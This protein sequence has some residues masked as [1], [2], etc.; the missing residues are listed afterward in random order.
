MTGLVSA[1]EFWYWSCPADCPPG[2]QPQPE[3]ALHDYATLHVP[4]RRSPRH[5]FCCW[6][7]QWNRPYSLCPLS[8]SHSALSSF[9]FGAS[10]RTIISALSWH[11]TLSRLCDERWALTSCATSVSIAAEATDVPAAMRSRHLDWDW[12]CASSHIGILC[13]HLRRSCDAGTHRARSGGR[14]GAQPLARALCTC[15]Q[16][17]VELAAFVEHDRGV[18]LQPASHK[19]PWQWAPHG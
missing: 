13:A 17:T 14:S 11:S 8:G 4:T 15:P 16:R 2:S 9:A 3:E 12:R 10:R 1:A 5:N 6:W 18:V 7:L 19:A